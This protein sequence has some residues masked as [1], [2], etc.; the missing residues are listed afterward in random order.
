VLGS[1]L[2]HVVCGGLISYLHYL[3]VLAY[4]DEKYT[5]C[6]AFVLFVFVLYIGCPMLPASLDYP[7]LTAALSVL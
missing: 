5:L 6:C 1:S 4:S 3:C 2:Q 7:Y